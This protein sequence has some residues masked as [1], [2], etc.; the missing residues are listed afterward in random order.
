M[1]GVIVKLGTPTVLINNAGIV[2][3][4]PLLELTPQQIERLL[5]QSATQQPPFI[6]LTMCPVISALTSFPIF[7]PCKPSSLV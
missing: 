2:N 3:G 5:F 6:L 7:I 4:K 1:I